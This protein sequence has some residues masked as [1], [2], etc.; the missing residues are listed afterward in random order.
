MKD[1]EIFVQ[2]VELGPLWCGWCKMQ[3][4]VRQLWLK[5]SHIVLSKEQY[6][7]N[8]ADSLQKTTIVLFAINVS[9]YLYIKTGAFSLEMA[10]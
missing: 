6:S 8:S 2:F 7:A 1:I 5:F 4:S 3:F 9:F 10:P